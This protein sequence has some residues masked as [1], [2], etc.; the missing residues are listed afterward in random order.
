MLTRGAPGRLRVWDAGGDHTG[1]EHGGDRPGRGHCAWVRVRLDAGPH[2]D[3]DH[4][5]QHLPLRW[6]LPP[7]QFTD[8]YE[9]FDLLRARHLLRA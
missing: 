3:P 7:P 4:Q 6:G 5:L 1:F 8:I 2:L 9:P